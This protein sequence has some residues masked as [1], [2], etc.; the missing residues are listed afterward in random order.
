MASLSLSDFTNSDTGVTSLSGNLPPELASSP[1]SATTSEVDP[2]AIRQKTSG[3]SATD[4]TNAAIPTYPNND[5]RIRISVGPKSK[6]FYLADNP[7]I[8]A[9]LASTGGVIFPY[10]PQI[11]VTYQNTYTPTAVTHSIN[12]IQS[13][14]NSDVSSITIN[15]TFTAQNMADADYVLAVL[16]F[17]RSASK[18]FFGSSTSLD[19]LGSPP[20]ILFLNG[21][22]QHYFPNVPTILTTFSHNMTDDVDFVEAKYGSEITMVPTVSSISLTLIPQYSRTAIR[23]FDL[24]KFAAGD[25]IREKGRFI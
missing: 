11:T 6:I 18:M 1:D 17:F 9:P 8:L 19:R 15:G 5:W 13:Y 22:G 12:S 23:S 2:S 25:L 21:F 7:G 24:D 10:T 3:L 16:H 20:P 14:V 4:D